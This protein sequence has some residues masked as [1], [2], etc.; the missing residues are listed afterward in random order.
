MV[1]RRALIGGA[2]A[3]VGSGSGASLLVGCADSEPAARLADLNVVQRFPQVLVPGEVRAPISFA[4]INGVITVERATRIPDMLTARLL[5]TATG[6]L[7]VDGISAS[8]HDEG[9][10]APYWPFRFTVSAPGIYTLIVDGAQETGAG[11]Q[12]SERSAILVP[13]VGDPLPG[14]DTPTFDNA[15]G[16]TPLCTRSP[17]ACPMHAV[18]LTEALTSG[19]PIAYLVGTPAYCSTGTCSPALEGLLAVRN[20]IG[21][22]M[23][24][25]H[26]EIYTDTTATKVAPAVTALNMTYEPALYITDNTGTIVERFD[27][28]FDAREINEALERHALV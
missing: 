23:I 28:V 17:E 14:F 21:D 2:I 4:D 26:A 13:L 6:S 22:A 18:T 3:M 27:A 5:N 7:V 12:V 25:I 20:R 11:V 10:E 19:K 1:S 24:F 8:R 9:L 16:I 15:R